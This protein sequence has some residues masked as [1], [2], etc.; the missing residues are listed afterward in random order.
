MFFIHKD[1][2]IK[3]NNNIDNSAMK[4]FNRLWNEELFKKVSSRDFSKA[5]NYAMRKYSIRDL[6]MKNFFDF[7]SEGS[8]RYKEACEAFDKNDIFWTFMLLRQFA[9]IPAYAALLKQITNKRRTFLSEKR[10]E[11]VITRHSVRAYIRNLMHGNT[12]NAEEF[13]ENA[14]K[15]M[16]RYQL[17]KEKNY[18]KSAYK[19]ITLSDK[20]SEY[21]SNIKKFLFYAAK[22]PITEENRAQTEKYFEYVG[23]Y[24]NFLRKRKDGS[25]V[26]ITDIDV[27]IA[28]VVYLRNGGN[29]DREDLTKRMHRTVKV[30]CAESVYAPVCLLTDYLYQIGETELEKMVLH[31]LIHYGGAINERYKKRFTCLDLMYQN[32]NR[33]IFRHKAHTPIECV[34]FKKEKEDF[35]KLLRKCID[36]KEENSWCI[37]IKHSFQ[38]Y[39]VNYKYFYDDKLLSTLESVYDNEFGDYVLEYSIRTFFS[40]DSKENASHSMIIITS[41][42]NQYTDFPKIGMMLKLEPISKKLVNVHYSVLYLPESS[43]SDEE[44]KNDEIYI[45]SILNDT[46]DSR[47]KTFSTVIENLTWSTVN[48]LFNK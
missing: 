6:C 10:K 41:G 32:S 15:D 11:S 19:L 21:T 2:D 22:R 27:I 47:F 17:L 24:Y 23:K 13:I 44:I 1:K 29:I 9:T 37:A 36:E 26:L 18:Y 35:G 3:V 5:Y 45:D 4:E 8:V 7:Q 48:N 28:M 42:K 33:F 20:P 25:Y 38:T 16:E 31:T 39:E 46:Q 30:Y 14:L 40:G 43:Y 34:L 12:K